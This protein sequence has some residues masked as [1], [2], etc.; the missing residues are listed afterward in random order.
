MDF[1]ITD[2]WQNQKAMNIHFYLPKFDVSSKMDLREGLK[3]LGVT[4]VFDGSL[5]D[6]SPVTDLKRVCLSKA[7]HAA[8]V[9]VD[10]EGVTA[11]AYTVMEANGAMP[12]QEEEIEFRL[13]RPF[14]FA[15]MGTGNVPLFVGIVNQP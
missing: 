3:T 6:F 14:L 9:T 5:A 13:D 11:A 7:N 12:S 10:E 2:E 15:I 8:R 1:L 4:D